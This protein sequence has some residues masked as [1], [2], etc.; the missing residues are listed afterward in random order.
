MRKRFINNTYMDY[1]N[2]WDWKLI[3]FK[4]YYIS[5]KKINEIDKKFKYGNLVYMDNGYYIVEFTPLE[6]NYN[7]RVF[8]DKERNVIFYY[9]D[10]S[11]KNGVINN[12][13]YYYD[14]YLDVIYCP[15]QRDKI[16]I[17]DEDELRDA[18]SK[19]EITQSEYNLAIVTAKKIIDEIKNGKNF[20]ININKKLLLQSLFTNNIVCKQ[21][22][23]K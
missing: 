3:N 18:L 15:Y 22:K 14:L 16:I 9:F 1:V 11:R 23:K 13:P 10:I 8:L 12:I 2:S 21:K 5:I 4:N 17:D 6:E 7:G 19:N 20:L